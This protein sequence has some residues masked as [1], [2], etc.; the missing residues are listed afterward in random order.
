MVDIIYDKYE[1]NYETKDI[2]HNV[3]ERTNINISYNVPKKIIKTK[4][5]NEKCVETGCWLFIYP[6]EE[7]AKMI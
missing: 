6:V 2:L 3:L 4:N 7:L 1:I 5:V